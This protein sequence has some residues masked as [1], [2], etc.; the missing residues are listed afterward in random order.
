MPVITD[1][2]V[3]LEI[4]DNMKLFSRKYRDF[5]DEQ[6]IL[7]EEELAD[8]SL[9]FIPPNDTVG[10]HVVQ[11]NIDKMLAIGFIFPVFFTFVIMIVVIASI[12]RLI[13]EDRA[14]VGTLLSLGVSK[15]KINFR[16][17]LLGIIASIAG[18]IIGI[19]IGYNTLAR[20]IYVSFGSM[21]FVPERTNQ[22]HIAF[23]VY[24]SL[25][26]LVVMI[27]AILIA[28]FKQMREKPAA[29][30]RQKAPKPGNKIWLERITPLWKKIRFSYKSSLRNIFR[31]PLNFLMNVVAL[32]GSTALI[33][34]GIALYDNTVGD[35]NGYG[36]F[37]ATIAIL[38]ILFA[39]ALSI[40]VTY[41]LTNMNI[42]ERKREI[43]TLKVLG[44]YKQEV[45]SY[46]FREMFIVSLIGILLGLPLGYFTVDIVFELI[47]FG[48]ADQ[49][50]WYSW[51]LVV[52][53]AIVF[54]G[55]S[56]LLLIR[57]ID[58]I[59]MNDSLKTLD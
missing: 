58:N 24:V 25:F 7:V 21:M 1:I 32:M 35:S 28:T 31:Y 40:L 43:A 2:H 55:I 18:S 9:I 36:A 38:I 16:Y 26:I 3:L 33:F 42:D 14:Q 17:Y 57:K 37:V 19:A 44:Y 47:D 49:I 23:G 5:I 52:A 6:I 34:A 20:L 53:I 46:I 45:R 39:A 29:L 50:N 59:D 8:E 41:N 48:S 12:G 30:L 4:P 54:I 51:P 22:I 11:S 10:Y 27:L 15:A 13:E 56:N